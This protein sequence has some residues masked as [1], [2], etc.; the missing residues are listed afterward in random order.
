MVGAGPWR[1]VSVTVDVNV[2]VP[3]AHVVALMRQHGG[4]IGVGRRRELGDQRAALVV[5]Q[6]LGAGAADRA[7]VQQGVVERR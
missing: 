6:R 3:D 2:L 7:S 5:Q 4:P 1:G